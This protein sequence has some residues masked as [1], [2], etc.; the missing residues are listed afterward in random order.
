MDRIYRTRVRTATA[1]T[2]IGIALVLFMLGV[3]GF[4]VLNARAL[5]RY[6]KE[7]VRVEVFLKRGLKEQDVMQFRKELDTEPWTLET[8]Y[9]T[10]DEA[11]EQL[12]Q[13]LGED[14][15]GV[16]G[17]NPLLASIELR[18]N[19]DHA[20]PDSLKWIVEHLQQDSRSHEVAY[21]AAVVRN[22]ENNM[23]KLG[24]AVLGFSALLLIIAV[25]LIN[26]TIRLAI[27][28][29]RFLIRTMHL[30]GATRWFIKK[31]FLGQSLWQGILSSVLAIGLLVLALRLVL[32]Y[33]PDLLAFT[34][35]TVLGALFGGVLLLGLVLSLTS[36]W[37]AV[38][39]YI[40]MNSED[41]YWS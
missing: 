30:V 28:S 17:S 19:A 34:D 9:V 23:N 4:L 20:H 2:V 10:A 40:R 39:R 32:R 35:A 3:L 26:N 1:G 33:V 6:F 37:F 41:L 36:T 15:L 5:E 24:L 22:I 7:N 8:R 12:K 11:A 16:L 13:D 31:P 21:N 25:A 14:F 38:R 29:Q 27:Y 18:L